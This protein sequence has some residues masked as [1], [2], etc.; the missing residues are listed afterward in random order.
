MPASAVSKL[1][2]RRRQDVGPAAVKDKPAAGQMVQ[3][4]MGRVP[5][6]IP[7]EEHDPVPLSDQ[8]RAK[9]TP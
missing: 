9:A 3:V 7:L 5:L 8:R 6:R 2:P 4:A 1:A